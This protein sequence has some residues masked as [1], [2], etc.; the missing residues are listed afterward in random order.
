MVDHGFNHEGMVRVPYSHDMTIYHGRLGPVAPIQ[1]SSGVFVEN[2]GPC[3]PGVGG[4]VDVA[5][6]IETPWRSLNAR[7]EAPAGLQITLF[8]ELDDEL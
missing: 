8:E 5:A 2:G 4:C 7:L 1:Q 3:A 6:P